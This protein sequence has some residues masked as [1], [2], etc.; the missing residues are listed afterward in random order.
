MKRLLLAVSMVTGCAGP[1]FHAD[2][3]VYGTQQCQQERIQNR[4]DLEKWERI[5]RALNPK[6]YG[7]P[8][9]TQH[10]GQGSL[11]P[12]FGNAAGGSYDNSYIQ[13]P[14][15]YGPGIHMDQYGRPVTY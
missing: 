13:T 14:N 11:Q 7:L 6:T 12:A 3:D 9:H 5:G 2:S 1:C 10:L 15:A 4:L 8:D